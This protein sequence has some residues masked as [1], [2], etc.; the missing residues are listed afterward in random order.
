MVTRENVSL[1]ELGWELHYDSNGKHPLVENEHVPI[2]PGEIITLYLRNRPVQHED[3]IFYGTAI[4]SSVK[5]PLFF[6]NMCRRKEKKNVFYLFGLEDVSNPSLK[7]KI[8][9]FSLWSK[10]LEDA[11]LLNYHTNTMKMIGNGIEYNYQTEQDAIDD[12]LKLH[13]EFSQASTIVPNFTGDIN[14]IKNR[15]FDIVGGQTTNA[16]GLTQREDLIFIEQ[17][18]FYSDFTMNF[19]FYIEEMEDFTLF[20]S[21]N[22]GFIRYDAVTGTF[23]IE[24]FPHIG[25]SA[26]AFVQKENL[27]VHTWYDFAV[28]YDRGEVTSILKGDILEKEHI[29]LDIGGVYSILADTSNFESIVV[30]SNFTYHTA[31]YHDTWYPETQSRIQQANQTL[32]YDY[33]RDEFFTMTVGE[34]RDMMK[35]T[36]LGKNLQEYNFTMVNELDD[37]YEF[38]MHYYGLHSTKTIDFSIKNSGENGIEFKTIRT[39]IQYGQSIKDNRAWTSMLVPQGFVKITLTVKDIIESPEPV[40]PVVFLLPGIPISVHKVKVD[41]SNYINYNASHSPSSS[42]APW[43]GYKSYSSYYHSYRLGFNNVSS[44]FA[45]LDCAFYEHWR[46][47]IPKAMGILLHTGYYGSGSYDSQVL[48]SSTYAATSAEFTGI[49]GPGICN[50]TIMMNIGIK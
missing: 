29:G 10:P 45:L 4:E 21:R 26:T 28:R 20:F 49:S 9:S 44:H 27:K 13:Y 19:R 5:F 47:Q 31:W 12:G 18:Y 30:D 38:Y 46:L 43:R 42:L 37:S 16:S 39:S 3:G 14:A 1:R 25:N 11:S 22:I 34:K 32:T 23:E 15:M 8:E 24:L 33:G 50:P 6:F 7:G 36:I 2:S 35:P 17:A 41:E 40:F 48:W